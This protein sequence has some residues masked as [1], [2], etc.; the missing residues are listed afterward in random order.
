MFRSKIMLALSTSWISQTLDDP[1]RLVNELNAVAVGGVELEYRLGRSLFENLKKPLREAGIRV[2]GLHNYCPSPGVI[3]KAPPSGDYFRLS[4]L[5]AEERKL[6][7]QWT[8]RTIE[9]AHDVEAAYVVLHCGLVEMDTGAQ[10][11]RELADAAG[12]DRQPL[13]RFLERKLALLE[14][15]KGPHLD[16]LL[17]SLDPLVQAAEKYRITLGIE[18]RYHY[19][20]LPGHTEFNR[21]FETFDGGPIGYWHD[22][23][24]AHAGEM[25]GLISQQELLE[26]RG[27]R[28][29]GIHLHDARGLD[30]HRAPGSGE[31]DFNLLM[32][33]L[34]PDLPVVIE[35]APGT[36]RE[37]LE[38]A[39][40]TARTICDADH[41]SDA[42][43]HE[44]I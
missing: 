25:L 15:R 9:Q 14:Q 23:G 24:H 32:P 18:N 11:V 43:D 31:I 41:I 42:P 21:I 35:L 19:N 6:A 16:A 33:Y 7:V 2:V 8:T 38:Q 3:P 12:Q 39:V 5:D 30:D 34:T 40:T 28:L 22:C 10:T 4:A 37:E 13:Q 44:K 29:V 27:N 26:A 36:R 20:E 17:F 1:Q